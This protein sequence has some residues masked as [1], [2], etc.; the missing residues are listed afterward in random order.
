MSVA[1]QNPADI[2]A[3]LEVTSCSDD[4]RSS[5]DAAQATFASLP[6]LLSA[7]IHIM[8]GYSAHAGTVHLLDSFGLLHL[9]ASEG[10][11]ESVREKL[12]TLPVGK[13]A[14]GLA[15]ERRQA[16]NLSNLRMDMASDAAA[17]REIPGLKQAL[18]LPI[19]RGDA[20]I[21]ALGIET[22]NERTFSEAEIAAL[23]DAGRSIGTRFLGPLR[24]GS[25]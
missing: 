18:A 10:I 9:V 8:Q 22:S 19:F 24:S 16:V 3:P 5:D 25:R 12:R 6:D 13:G 23:L 4:D 17:E 2:F 1:V 14:S 20:V 21:G 11:P 7:L 15:I